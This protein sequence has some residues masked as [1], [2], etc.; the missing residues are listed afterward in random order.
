MSRF[1]RVSALVSQPVS[2]Q[3]DTCVLFCTVLYCVV[4]CCAVLYCV[5]CC[6]VF[7]FVLC[8]VEVSGSGE[9]VELCKENKNPTLRMWGKKQISVY[10]KHMVK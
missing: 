2:L 10:Q 8:C 5:L 1:E 7:V 3:V 6:V 9:A 4:L